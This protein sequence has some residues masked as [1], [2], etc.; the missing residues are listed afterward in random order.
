M[1]ARQAWRLLQNPSSLCAQV[2]SSRYYPGCSILRARPSSG[3]SYAWRS[4]LKGVELLRK[5]IIWRV[6]N[7]KDID[8]WSDPWI[9]RGNTRRVVSHRGN[10]L[11]TK[12]SEL[13]NPITN[14]WDEELVRQTFTPEDTKCILQIPIQDHLED[15]TTWHYD[16]KG[17]F[18]VKSA[19]K[20]A[21]DCAARESLSGLTSTSSA[22]EEDGGFDWLKLWTMPLPN[23]VLH[24]L[25][26]LA[27]NSLP[28]RTKLQNRGT[29]EREG[30]SPTAK[31]KVDKTSFRNIEDQH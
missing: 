18:S 9:P 7:G 17:I 30:D 27:T 3:I 10:N 11:I 13:I 15:F 21:I 31:A 20:V 24:F 14:K 16:K 5:G 28:L 29:G 4:I 1:L 22:A 12:V 19:Y 6:G 8:I 2:L 23:K 26:R 25:W